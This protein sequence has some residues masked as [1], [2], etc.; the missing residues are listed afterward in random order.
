MQEKKYN[1]N[2]V[3]DN[4]ELDTGIIKVSIKDGYN[5]YLPSI[6]CII[7]E[8]ANLIRSDNQKEFESLLMQLAEKSRASGI[9]LILST[10]RPSMGAVKGDLKS[11]L[12]TRIAFKVASKQDSRIIIDKNGAESL[13]G[14]G[15]MLFFRYNYRQFSKNSRKLDRTK[16]N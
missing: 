7:D 6:V 3:V 11:N 16:R 5:F 8:L 2:K 4:S 14:K 12:P 10:Q 15:D 9:H 1:S 13:L